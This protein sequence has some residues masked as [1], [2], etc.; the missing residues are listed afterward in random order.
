MVDSQKHQRTGK[1]DSRHDDSSWERGLVE[2]VVL[3]SI[4]EQK[5][6]RRWGILFKSLTFIYLFALLVLWWPNGLTS[7]TGGDEKH[8][9]LVEIKGVIAPETEAS[10]DD[11][12]TALREAFEDEETKG[13]ILR[14]NS[15]G[16]SPVQAGYIHDEV[17]RLKKEHP[18]TPVY[19]VIVDVCAS[20]GYYIAAAA[21][22]IYA[23]K[24]S[25]VGSIGVMMNG[26]GFVQTLEELGVERRLLTAGEN[27]GIMDPFSPLE[28]D[29][30]EHVQTI[31][32]ELHQQF[33]KVVQQGR[34]E[35]LKDNAE[36]FSGLFW[37]GEKSVELGLID[38]LGSS[39]YVAREL[40]GAETIVKFTEEKD[41]LT[42]LA[43]RMGASMASQL[44]KITGL[45]LVPGLR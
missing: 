38:G 27:K 44:V 24:G 39:S 34:G 22:E 30:K 25:L 7:A 8:T 21:D 5:R 1:A 32:D 33:I 40:I 41:L 15:P 13:V 9:A 10:A 37:S 42:R 28:V 12:V 4:T 3:A 36:I 17:L 6:A 43:E 19:A 26:F 2:T 31:L 11:V 16:G 20:G 29:D 45:D 23:D 14:I 18:D 35:R